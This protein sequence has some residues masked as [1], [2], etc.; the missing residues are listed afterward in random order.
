MSVALIVAIGE[1]IV[2]V[3]LKIDPA[4]YARPPTGVHEKGALQEDILSQSGIQ[5]QPGALNHGISERVVEQKGRF[6]VAVVPDAEVKKVG[7]L[8]DDPDCQSET[9]LQR[10]E[11]VGETLEKLCTVGSVD[12]LLDL[13]NR[14]FRRYP[15]SQFSLQDVLGDLLEAFENQLANGY[16]F[17]EIGGIE[18][19]YLPPGGEIA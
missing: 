7:I 5:R 17:V 16:F 18:G 6:H 9:V 10:I 4:A 19:S 15:Y 12:R 1:D 14:A 8:L 13:L 2:P 11:P 3:A